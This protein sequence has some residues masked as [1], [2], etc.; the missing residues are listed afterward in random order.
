MFL[1]MSL[2]STDWIFTPRSVFPG[3]IRYKATIQNRHYCDF[4][5]SEVVDAG[6]CVTV[7]LWKLGMVVIEINVVVLTINWRCDF[8]AWLLYLLR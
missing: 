8:L 2:Y 1:F 5:T 3:I 4:I 6:L 7:S